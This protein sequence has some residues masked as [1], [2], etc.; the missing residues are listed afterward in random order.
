MKFLLS[1][2][3][4]W[5]SLYLQAQLITEKDLRQGSSSVAT[6]EQLKGELRLQKDA[7]ETHLELGKAYYFGSG[8]KQNYKKAKKHFQKAAKASFPQAELYLAV[9]QAE[10]KGFKKNPEKGWELL[11][12]LAKREMPLAQ[13]LVS[14]MYAAGVGSNA[15][16]E[17]SIY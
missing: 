14:K 2:A 3:L 7:P 17:K 12:H 13:Y 11:L 10:G 4:L 1:I 15:D 8:V 9:M 16:E 6:V 5:C